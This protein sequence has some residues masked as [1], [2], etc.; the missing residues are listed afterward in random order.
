MSGAKTTE[1]LIKL[2][3]KNGAEGWIHYDM[4]K[5]LLIDKKFSINFDKKIDDTVESL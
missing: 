5:V 3:R 2:K 4:F 1:L